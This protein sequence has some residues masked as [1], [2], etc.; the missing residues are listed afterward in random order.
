MDVLTSIKLIGG[1]LLLVVAITVAQKA[2]K[3]PLKETKP[4]ATENIK[5]SSSL[6]PTL[7]H[8]PTVQENTAQQP[9]GTPS[10]TSTNS[11]SSLS[12]SLDVF[13]YPN[14]KLTK[15]EGNTLTL[16]SS[17]SPQRITDWY[18][19]KIKSLGMSAKSFVQTSTNGNVLNKLAGSDGTVEVNAEIKK[20]NNESQATIT[21]SVQLEDSSSSSVKI[22]I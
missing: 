4:V 7:T 17:D 12:L 18:K 2:I 16:E 13:L 10:P 19:E 21:V 3:P 11:P 9:T 1:L 22:K 14:S 5:P 20:Q 8:T 6:T 15:K